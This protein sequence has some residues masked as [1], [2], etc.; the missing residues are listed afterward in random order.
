M[1]TPAVHTWEVTGTPKQAIRV[2]QNEGLQALNLKTPNFNTHDDGL[3][4]R[5]T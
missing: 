4:G 1:I 3:V 5:N 2:S